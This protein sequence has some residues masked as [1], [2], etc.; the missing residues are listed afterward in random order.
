MLE[1]PGS[2]IS[3]SSAAAPEPGYL[4]GTLTPTM[5]PFLAVSPSF[6]MPHET[7]QPPQPG[8]FLSSED[9]SILSH[10]L[11][12][13]SRAISFDS[14]D[15]YAYCVGLPNLAFRSRPLMS[16]LL[17]L[18]ALCMAC[19]LIF[20]EDDVVPDRDH[21][22][23]LVAY[24]RRQHLESQNGMY[25]LGGQPQ[26]QG[27]RELA[28]AVLMALY[29]VA[30]HRVASWWLDSAPE[31]RDDEANEEDVFRVDLQWLS[32]YRAAHTAYL[33][34]TGAGL[35]MGSLGALLSGTAEATVPGP[36][37]YEEI[38]GSGEQPLSASAHM[39]FPALSHTWE[40]A[41]EKLRD[42]ARVLANDTD[43]DMWHA[44]TTNTRTPAQ[45]CV[46]A[47]E[48]LVDIASEIFA[49]GT[50]SSSSVLIPGIIPRSRTPQPLAPGLSI[51]EWLR[52]FAAR[53]TGA[54]PSKPLR[55]IVMSFLCKAPMGFM[56]L[57]QQAWERRE[58]EPR[59][60]E[61]HEAQDL[62]LN[63]FA[64]WLAMTMLLDGVWWIGDVGCRNLGKMIV[65]QFQHNERASDWWPAKMYRLNQ[66]LRGAK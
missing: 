12:H 35:H 58:G 10:Y 3:P 43:T 45:A 23:E 20:T 13:T 21:V 49:A 34:V 9:L 16:S 4:S 56:S 50:L 64:H 54:V 38:I 28:N 30:Y 6:D 33:S 46:V 18:T 39:L 60:G 2:S 11:Q 8:D 24:A 31:D 32:S 48:A 19:D 40:E 27:E 47:I 7:F 42:Q 29:G 25:S 41:I 53:T 37:S 57:V 1:S 44:G 22:H 66:E 62:A 65:G 14:E 5:P 26:Q 52:A 17:A 59:D 36:I 51:S 63:V 55:S 61:V 15:N